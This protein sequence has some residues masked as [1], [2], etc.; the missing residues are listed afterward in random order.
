MVKS[1]KTAT[2]TYT[3]EQVEDLL[4]I[5]RDLIQERLRSVREEISSYPFL[6]MAVA[7]VLGFAL[8]VALSP[9]PSK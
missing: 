6:S 9:R 8:G 2:K 3:E 4:E 7:F 1:G 5:Q